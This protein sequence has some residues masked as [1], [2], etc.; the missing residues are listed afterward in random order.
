[1]QDANDVGKE[2]PLIPEIKKPDFSGLGEGPVYFVFDDTQKIGPI[3]TIPIRLPDAPLYTF[4]GTAEP[5]SLAIEHLQ[6]VIVGGGDVF[7]TSSTSKEDVN[8]LNFSL[9]P[10]MLERIAQVYR[11]MLEETDV[12]IT[13]LS[14]EPNSDDRL[15]RFKKK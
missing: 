12:E 3:Q 10:D 4:S 14:S 9:T 8:G 15:E 2:K 6:N 13:P 5:K 7:D 11:E 1:M